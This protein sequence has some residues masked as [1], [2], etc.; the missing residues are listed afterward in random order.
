M[1]T[2]VILLLFVLVVGLAIYVRLAPV[3]PMAIT[4]SY[5][6]D[7]QLTGGYVAVRTVSGQPQEVIDAITRIALA[8][9]RTVRIDGDG[10]LTFVT[11][12]ALFGFPDVTRVTVADG[13]MTIHAHLVYGR[14]DMGV[15]KARVLNWLNQLGPLTN[16]V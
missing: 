15:N 1:M 2:K 11:R 16:D 7:T 8:T 6:Q 10:D 9:P 5:D 4:K 13:V 12:S 3:K 14:S